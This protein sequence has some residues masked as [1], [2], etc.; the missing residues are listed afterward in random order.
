[1]LKRFSTVFLILLVCVCASVYADFNY[2]LGTDEIR[3]HEA[4]EMQSDTGRVRIP[5]PELIIRFNIHDEEYEDAFI[6]F[7]EYCLRFNTIAVSGD[8]DFYIYP[9]NENDFMEF[10][11]YRGDDEYRIMTSREGDVPFEIR[12]HDKANDVVYRTIITIPSKVPE[13]NEH[14]DVEIYSDVGTEIYSGA[15]FYIRVLINGEPAPSSWH[16]FMTYIITKQDGEIIFIATPEIEGS[17][18]YTHRY[19]D[20]SIG[21]YATRPAL[22]AGTYNVIV[23]YDRGADYN[24][25]KMSCIKELTVLP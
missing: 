7:I 19:V 24:H 4:V 14:M 22:E 12:I 23:I 11:M 25:E 15:D 9:V 21:D 8:Y 2:Y 10:S 1:M 13:N 17:M 3:N 6:P 16:R 20:M 5:Q 18:E